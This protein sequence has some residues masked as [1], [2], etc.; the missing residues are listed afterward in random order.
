GVIGIALFLS[1]ASGLFVWL[2]SSSRRWVKIDKRAS[3]R[4][5]VYDLHR[6]VGLLAWLILIVQGATGIGLAYPQ[7]LGSVT[8]WFV[9]TASAKS[10]QKI[11]GT[12]HYGV[13][14]P[15][16]SL[17]DAMQ[18]AQRA[19]P[20]GEIREIRLPGSGGKQLTVRF[21][22]AGDMHASGSNTV[23]LDASGSRVVSVIKL[24]DQPVARRFIESLTPI[25]YGEW[26]GLPARVLLAFG[27][28]A[29]PVLVLS[30]V[31][32]RWWP[33]KTRA[34]VPK[35]NESRVAVL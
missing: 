34:S 9:P 12:K 30:G 18:L 13:A 33:Q 26:G 14:T 16:A 7:W 8:A 24:S 28:S 25:H 2:I 1:S 29:L 15:I 22:C 10:A 27:G 21:W 5:M 17:A 19:M 4:R 6:S 31:L 11:P 20:D 3:T 35:A 23:Y 32:I